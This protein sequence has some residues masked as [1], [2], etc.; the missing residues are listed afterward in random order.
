MKTRPYMM[1]RA[2][3]ILLT[4][5]LLGT[6]SA[7]PAVL[8]GSVSEQASSVA[9]KH[10]KTSVGRPPAAMS[11]CRTGNQSQ[12]LT[13]RME[14]PGCCHFSLP[15]SNQSRPALLGS[16]SGEVRSHIQLQASERDLVAVHLQTSLCSSNVLAIAFRCDRSDT[17]L[18]SSS[19]RI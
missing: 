3:P 15:S 1:K 18:R 6:Y 12:R 10:C 13:S 8:C 7:I 16:L 11:C 17:Y 19:L 5:L 4:I 14:L 2:I 9:P